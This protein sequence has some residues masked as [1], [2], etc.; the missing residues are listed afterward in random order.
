[1][2]RLRSWASSMMI[3]SYWRSIRSRW[4]SASRTPSVM[5]LTSVRSP[6]SSVNRTFQPTTSPSGEPIS[7]AI[8]SAPPPGTRALRAA[9]GPRR[10]ADLLGD[11]LGHRA[12]RDPP[13]LG[14]PDPAPDTP[15]ELQQDLRQLGGLARAGLP[16][17][18]DDLRLPQRGGDVL[19][20]LTDR[21]VLGVGDDRDGGAA[22]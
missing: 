6:T 3:V 10:R 18:D 1:M 17:D 16:R 22:A 15:A 19:A 11:P 8:R 20:P 7:S 5:S 21:Q 14:V 9:A 12:G 13:R 2:L 4:T